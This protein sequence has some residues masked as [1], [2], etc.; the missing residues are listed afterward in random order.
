MMEKHKMIGY[1]FGFVSTAALMAMA[2][3]IFKAQTHEATGHPLF[4][5]LTAHSCW[6]VSF[7]H[8]NYLVLLFSSVNVIFAVSFGLAYWFLKI[9]P[10][11]GG[12]H[13]N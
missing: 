3:L 5:V 8:D 6:A 2:Y 12:R 9:V 7:S 10:E 11:K 13:A 1:L 4:Y